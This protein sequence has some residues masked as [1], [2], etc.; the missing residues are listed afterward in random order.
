MQ[1]SLEKTVMSRPDPDYLT[2]IT[3]LT[4]ITSVERL[5]AG[6]YRLWPRILCH[7]RGGLREGAYHKVRTEY[8][9]THNKRDNESE[10]SFAAHLF[11]L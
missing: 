10:Y 4:P 7:R 1:K 11:L 5:R 9:A 2:P 3:C 6:R 8:R